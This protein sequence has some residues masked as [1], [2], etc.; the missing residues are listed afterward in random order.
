MKSANDTS[1][2]YC[3]VVFRLKNGRVDAGKFVYA[4]ACRVE[5][6]THVEVVKLE[7]GDLRYELRPS[8][9]AD[10]QPKDHAG[11]GA[12]YEQP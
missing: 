9:H 1:S 3:T 12:G 10:T 11:E 7:V 4:L 8:L 5:Q 2:E 6:W